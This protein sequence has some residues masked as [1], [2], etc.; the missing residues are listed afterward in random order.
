ML[1]SE[2][3]E[4]RTSVN[5]RGGS[6]REWKGRVHRCP[7]R[8]RLPRGDPGAASRDRC[9]PAP[10]R[11]HAPSSPHRPRRDARPPPLPSRPRDSG[12][13]DGA[14]RPV[15]ALRDP[16]RALPSR[17]A[18]PGR[19]PAAPAPPPPPPPLPPHLARSATA[20]A[21]SWGPAGSDATTARAG[22]GV[23]GT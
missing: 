21:A 16:A 13:A 11:P 2:R 17:A 5:H 15:L 3:G 4:G 8:A 22:A 9:G 1:P 7:F 6:F 14:G 10:P 20:A 23:G 12:A 19:V 18:E